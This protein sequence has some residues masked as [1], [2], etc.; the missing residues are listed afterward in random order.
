MRGLTNQTLFERTDARR[1]LFEI[2]NYRKIN[3]VGPC[4]EDSKYEIL[5]RLFQKAMEG[6]L[7]RIAA[8]GTGRKRR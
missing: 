8:N 6:K 5:K 1:K 4:I 7:E 2:L 3:Y